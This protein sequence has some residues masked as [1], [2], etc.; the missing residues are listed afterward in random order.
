MNSLED[1]QPNLNKDG[2]REEYE[3]QVGKHI[4]DPWGSEVNIRLSRLSGPSL[5]DNV[6]LDYGLTAVSYR[7]CSA[8]VQL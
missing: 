3:H 1:T 5:T 7:G 8:A 2:N 6:Q 4:A